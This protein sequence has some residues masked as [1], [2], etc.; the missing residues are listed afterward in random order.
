MKC[1][2][3]KQC[4]G[5]KYTHNKYQE[6][7]KKKES[8]LQSLGLKNIS[9]IIAS[10]NPFYYR[11]KVRGAFGCFNRQVMMG[12]YM[13][14]SH[15]IVETDNCLIE[16][17]KAQE[18]NQ[19]I[20][21]LAVSF[22]W[23]IYDE[24]RRFG[25]LR[26]SLIRVGKKS[27][28]ILVTIVVASEKIPSKNNFTKALLKK[29]PEITT[30]VFNINNRNTSLILGQKE[31]VQYGPGFIIDELLGIKFRISSQS[32]YQVNVEMTEKLYTKALELGNFKQTDTI[33]D[34]YCG[35]GTI[36]LYAVKF[37]KKVYG[38]EYNKVAIKDAIKNAKLN[39]I[40]NVYFTAAD[41]GEYLQHFVNEKIPIDGM[42]V[43]PARA[44]LDPKAIDGILKLKPK[45]LVYISCQPESLVRDLKPLSKFYNIKVVQPVDMFP[46]T[47]HVEC[48]AMM[49][50][51]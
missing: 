25:L 34:A 22:K 12:Q 41:T 36:S 38:V 40:K 33:I 2:I 11:N 43:D 24:D 32:F 45:T 16:D 3:F 29:H 44:G 13:E 17:K 28:E 10:D 4:G 42:I 47:K 6:S 49:S 9:P 39:N 5:C 50:R 31:L 37:V 14:D 21:D 20:K 35:I 7:L 8:Y 23:K 26:S 1:P 19:T 46:F 18:I 48:I 30:V 27:K 15:R 51:K